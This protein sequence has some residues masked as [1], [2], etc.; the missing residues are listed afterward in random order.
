MELKE[1]D[2]ELYAIPDL[3]EDELNGPAPSSESESSPCKSDQT[4][5]LEADDDC[6]K[7]DIEL[8]A[9]RK[10]GRMRPSPSL[11]S[12]A[13]SG[14]RRSSRESLANIKNLFH[15]A[16]NHAADKYDNDLYGLVDD[17]ENNKC[18][19]SVVER[20]VNKRRRTEIEIYVPVDQGD[21]LFTHI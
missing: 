8:L 16:C 11:I 14:H 4:D 10:V 19:V 1:F 18:S 12:F 21:K 2:N 3:S 6:L 5:M 9:A 17:S 7:I 20:P 15:T 13:S